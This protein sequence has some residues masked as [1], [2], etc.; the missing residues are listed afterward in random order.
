V[1]AP[2]P[3]RH[4]GKNDVPYTRLTSGVVR[5]LR[6]LSRCLRG[7]RRRQSS[8]ADAD[9]SRNLDTGCLQS[10]PHGDGAAQRDGDTHAIAC[11]HRRIGAN[12]DRYCAAEPD[13]YGERS[14]EQH[15]VDDGDADQHTDADQPSA[16]P[17]A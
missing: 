17:H 1:G 4:R 16:Q 3:D 8:H 6:A 2:G 10:N 9:R 5:R 12:H 7:E 11:R 13:R 14:A 15:G